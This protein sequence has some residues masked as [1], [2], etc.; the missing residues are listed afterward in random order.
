MNVRPPDGAGKVHFS[1]GCYDTI[2]APPNSILDPGFYYL[3]YTAGGQGICGNKNVVLGQD[4][5][6]EINHGDFN[7]SSCGNLSQACNGCAFGADPASPVVDGATSYTYF[8]A[9]DANSSWCTGTCP[10]KGLLV[11][12]LPGGTGTFNVKGPAASGYFKGTIFWPSACV[13]HSNATGDTL[14][15]FVCDTIL[16][17]GGSG[18]GNGVSYAGGAANNANVEAALVE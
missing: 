14:G 4:V 7:E 2:S 9:P 15:Q 11:Y 17:Q 5:T 3:G 16:V 18:N 8:A 6:I 1:P 10:L 13:Y 12:L